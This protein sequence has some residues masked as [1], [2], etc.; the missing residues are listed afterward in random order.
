MKKQKLKN[1]LKLGILTFGISLVLTN[2]N[3]NEDIAPQ[4]IQ[5]ERTITEISFEDFKSNSNLNNQF[6]S[7][8]KTF[9]EFKLSSKNNLSQKSSSGFEDAT[10]ITDK[11]IKIKKDSFTTYT[12]TILTQ[13][14]NDEFYN[15]V[16]Y[17]NNNQE[18]YKSHILQYTPSQKWLADTSKYFSGKVKIIGNDVFNVDGLLQSK[19]SVSAKSSQLDDCIDVRVT[20]ECSN[21]REGH[22]ESPRSSGCVADDFYVYYDIYSYPCPGGSGDDGGQIDP[23]DNPGNGNGG[24]GSDDDSGIVT[25]PNTVPYT[26][27]LKNFQSGTLNAI[28]R[29]YYNRDSNIKNTIDRYLIDRN[30]SSIAKLDAKSALEF[31]SNLN[32]NFQQ[33]NWVFNNRNSLDLMD[34]KEDLI[35]SSLESNTIAVMKIDAN[36]AKTGWDFSRTGTFP[37]RPSLT[38]KATFKPNQGET[39][40]LL[41]N[42]LV[43]YQ[44]STKRVVNKALPNTIASSEVITDGYNYIFN[45]S[46]NTWYEYRMPPATPNAKADIDFLLDAFWNGVKIVGRYATPL[47]DA[48]I[49]IDGNDF[50]GIAQN[51][52]QTAG[53]MIVGLI[54]GGKALKPVTK[55]V[56]GVIKYQK[57]VKVTVNGVSKNITLPINI[58]NGIVEF[59]SDGY[60]RTQLRK[61]LNITDS[62]IQGHHIVPLNLKDLDIVQKAAKSDNVFHISDKLNGIPLPST[63]HLTGHNSIGGYSDTVRDILINFSENNQNIDYNSAYN[64]LNGL[65]NHIRG[66]IEANPNM[67]MGQISNL[68]SYP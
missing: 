16:L 5:Q 6:Q 12:F 36:R 53:F 27:Q 14:E 63:N 13:T 11:I 40:Y 51:K 37:N 45:Y 65:T 35:E 50:D 26:S 33:F 31:S 56:N 34:I 32:L 67:N 58:V 24:G 39:M 55:I 4:E 66:V 10:I 21:G 49:L 62:A 61:I 42:G 19:S 47:E 18:I 22:Q 48:I 57:I 7:L 17:V 38:Y 54:P 30:F 29:T 23:Y 52:V 25:A 15:L 60:N 46:S 2:C 43:L 59:G 3:K 68:I 44:S 8:D 9:N 20:Y 1:L 41:N 64:F 28:E